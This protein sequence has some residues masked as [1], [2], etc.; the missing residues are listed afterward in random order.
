MEP[1]EFFII[2]V[3]AGILVFIVKIY[4]ESRSS[5]FTMHKS[6]I[7][8]KEYMV[9][10]TRYK[11]TASDMLAIIRYR[12][13]RFCNYM[14]KTHPKDKKV[15]RLIDR[16]NPDN[17]YENYPDEGKSTS[18]SLNKGEKIY[19]CL[20][21]REKHRKMVNFNVIM[22]VAFHEMAHVM[23]VSTGHTRAHTRDGRV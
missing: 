14:A 10:N 19:F 11:Q 16:F 5:E 13:M 2:A 22:F 7:D 23:S 3:I 15:K 9:K 1:I 12:L 8:G 20:R 18:Y 17:I 6:K 4:V 21:S